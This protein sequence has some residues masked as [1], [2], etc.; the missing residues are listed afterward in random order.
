MDQDLMC[1]ANE[2]Q[3][4]W[5]LPQG[6]ARRLRAVDQPRWMVAVAGRLWLTRSGAGADEREADV[7]LQPGQRQALPA[8]SEWVVEGWQQAAF[9]LLASPWPLTA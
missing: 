3:T 8:G 1:I 9:V 6:Q 5:V 7:W 2:P 4:H